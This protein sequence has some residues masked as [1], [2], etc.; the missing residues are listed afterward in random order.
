MKVYGNRF[1]RAYEYSRRMTLH[2]EKFL[3]DYMTNKGYIFSTIH[4]R[5]KRIRANGKVSEGDKDI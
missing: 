2:S 4:I 1:D 5:F 3:Y